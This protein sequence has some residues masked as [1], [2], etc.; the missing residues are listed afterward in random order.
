MKDATKRQFFKD[1]RQSSD[2]EE[3]HDPLNSLARCQKRSQG[4]EHLFKRFENLLH[5]SPFRD[6][7]DVQFVAG[8][9]EWAAGHRGQDGQ[10]QGRETQS[11]F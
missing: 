4:L 9:Q 7:G 6:E 5:E 8:H 10:N 11:L 2:T 3:N 1:G